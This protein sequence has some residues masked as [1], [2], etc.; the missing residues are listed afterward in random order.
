M[1]HPSLSNTTIGWYK[2]C[3]QLRYKGT[4]WKG[5]TKPARIQITFPELE[6]V[7]VLSLNNI[8]FFNED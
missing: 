1:Y 6:Q 7:I 5:V 3:A 2:L 4:K 8:H